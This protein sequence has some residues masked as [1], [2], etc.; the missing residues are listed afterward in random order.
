M[1]TRLARVQTESSLKVEG[2]DESSD[3]GETQRPP[4]ILISAAR[5]S[6]DIADTGFREGKLATDRDL[7]AS[8]HIQEDDRSSVMKEEKA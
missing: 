7:E 6:V 1:P 4:P 5:M 2:E 3:S 8:L